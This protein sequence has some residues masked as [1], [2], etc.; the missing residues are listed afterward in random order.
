[1]EHWWVN[2]KQTFKQEV[3]GGYLWSPK[4]NSNGARSHF[5]D[6]MAKVRPGDLIFSYAGAEIQAIGVATAKASSAN[7]P[8][9][10]GEAGANWD[11]DGWYV[12]VEFKL[13][14]N[15]LRP[16][17]HMDVIGPLLA[18]K[19]AP[20]NS[21]GNGNQGAYLSHISEELAQRLFGLIKAPRPSSNLLVSV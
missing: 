17:S 18:D 15:P 16:K 2:H 9:E 7:K 1:M 8:S 21:E 13:L 14:D 3:S 10:F 5:Y 11:N 20:L 6:N 4:R 19:Y 12:P